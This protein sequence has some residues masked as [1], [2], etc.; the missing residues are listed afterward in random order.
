MNLRTA[1]RLHDAKIA[2][3][4]II[5]YTNGRTLAEFMDDDYFQGAVE[6]RFEVLA[7]ALRGAES[8]APEI[9]DQFPE[10]SAIIGLR[11]RIA[12][13]YDDLD[14]ATLWEIATGDIPE[15]LP[16][17]ETVLE[18]IALPEDFFD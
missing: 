5:R 8:I 2:A 1:K 4:R 10:M 17:I 16:R 14:Y 18:S 7:E 15:L 13:S 9:R 12:H 6:R 11:N 3:E